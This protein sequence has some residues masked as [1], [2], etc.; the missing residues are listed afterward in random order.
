M[1][2]KAVNINLKNQKDKL[3][4]RLDR[5]LEEAEQLVKTTGMPGGIPNAPETVLDNL[6]G[7]CEDH[8]FWL[9]F[10]KA[11]P[12]MFCAAIESNKDIKSIRDLSFMEELLKVRSM[13]NIMSKKLGTTD[14]DV[15]V[16]EFSMA[17]QMLENKLSVLTALNTTVEGDSDEKL[18]FNV[19]GTNKAVQIDLVKLRDAITFLDSSVEE[20]QASA[21]DHMTKVE[22]IDLENITEEEFLNKVVE[23]CGPIK[24][25]D[26]MTLSKDSFI[27]IFKY[28]GDFA[29]LRSKDIKQAAQI[30]RCKHFEIDNKAYL[31][32]L[33]ATVQ[34]E[35]KA[36]E[37]ASNTLF[38][39]LSISPENFERS[40]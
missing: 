31:V 11:A 1:L 8:Q 9:N 40:Q 39:K 4:E 28:A 36:Y 20:K 21:E 33:Q 27:K 16:I 26:N 10:K 25:N 29:K 19:Q 12:M 17:T 18:T 23:V 14:A 38:D 2:K 13:M 37:S 6:I 15:D 7:E 32:A 24:K 3:K 30:E 34:E 35:E 22:E 5:K